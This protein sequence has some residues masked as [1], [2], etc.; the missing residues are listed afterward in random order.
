MRAAH[1]RVVESAADQ[2]SIWQIREAGVGASHIPGE[3]EAWPS[4]EDAAVPPE[5][6]GEYLRAFKK[7]CGRY[8]YAYTVF[9]HFGDGCVHAR[10]TFGLKTAE[11]VTKFRAYMQEAA[12][13]CLSFGGSLSGEHGD[14]QAKGELLPRMF[15]SELIQAFRDFKSIWD[16]HWRMNPGKLIDAQPLDADL[17]LGPDYRLRDVRTHFKYPND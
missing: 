7:L 14:G 13:L 8:G 2:A 9:G 17:R 11:G 3:E 6:L 10:M 4:W 15:G 12:D 16:P 5:R 1:A